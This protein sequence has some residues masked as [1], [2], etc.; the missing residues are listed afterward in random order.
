MSRKS[1]TNRYG[2]HIEPY[3]FKLIKQRRTELLCARLQNQNPFVFAIKRIF[4][5]VEKVQE[6]QARKI[7]YLLDLAMLL[8]YSLTI[9]E[10]ESQ[11]WPSSVQSAVPKI[12]RH[13]VF[14]GNAG[15]SFSRLAMFPPPP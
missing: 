13:S 7:P 14:V 6:R 4:L 2:L 3:F 12:L 10:S 11:Y 8:C 15:L 9:F 1:E 5:L